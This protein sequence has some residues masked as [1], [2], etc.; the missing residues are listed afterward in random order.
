MWDHGPNLSGNRVKKENSV[1][2]GQ[3]KGAIEGPFI[4]VYGII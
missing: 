3:K 4:R 2:S 1:F